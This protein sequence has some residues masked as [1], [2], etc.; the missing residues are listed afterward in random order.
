MKS[1]RGN[2]TSHDHGKSVARILGE[3]IFTFFN[4]LNIFLGLCLVLVG[5][6]RNMLF[7][8]VVVCN[9]VIG[10][11]QELR[12]RNTVRRLE[13]LHAMQC[14]VLRDTR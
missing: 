4:L 14:R 8:G 3:N 5:S 6:Y 10:I 11:V 2:R 7:L 9:T 12:A 13:L 1:G